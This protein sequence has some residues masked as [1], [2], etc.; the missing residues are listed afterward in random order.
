MA[1][2]QSASKQNTNLLYYME[3]IPEAQFYELFDSRI[4]RNTDI[5]NIVIVVF[6]LYACFPFP[7][8]LLILRCLCKRYTLLSL[9][10]PTD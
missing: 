3:R 2:G 9:V 10:G 6:T 4:K 7:L 5:N 1:D 8:S